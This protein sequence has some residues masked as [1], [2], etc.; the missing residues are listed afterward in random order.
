MISERLKQK[1][2]ILTVC[3]MND[4]LPKKGDCF[5]SFIAFNDEKTTLI[6]SYDSLL[7]C[8]GEIRDKEF[9]ISSQDLRFFFTV[10]DGCA[11]EGEKLYGISVG[12]YIDF[13]KSMTKQELEKSFDEPWK[14][15]GTFANIAD[16][17]RKMFIKDI[18]KLV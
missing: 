18:L 6:E 14:A 5:K 10:K 4:R 16:N 12:S 3:E 7:I 13:G 8:Q 11:V 2:K 15:K 1:C 17:M 9:L